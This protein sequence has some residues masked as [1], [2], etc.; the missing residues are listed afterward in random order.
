M[1]TTLDIEDTAYAIAKSIAR[2]RNIGLGR[3][4]GE[5][6]LKFAHPEDEPPAAKVSTRKGFP[7]VRVGRVITSEEVSKILDETE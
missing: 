1:R 5:I 7:V 2:E 3:A 6:I 4:I